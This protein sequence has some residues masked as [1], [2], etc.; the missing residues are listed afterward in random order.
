MLVVAAAAAA[1]AV[2]AAVAVAAVDDED[3]VQW[4]RWGGCSMAAV[5]FDS[6]GDGL[7][8]GYGKG[9][10]ANDTSVGRW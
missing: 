7:W 8:I 4:R 10:M 9:R 5:A 3:G 6:K 2:T 1:R